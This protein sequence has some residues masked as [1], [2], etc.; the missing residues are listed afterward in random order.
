MGSFSV[1][2]DMLNLL[3]ILTTFGMFGMIAM[4]EDLVAFGMLDIFVVYM[5]CL[6]DDNCF[7]I[8]EIMLI[9]Q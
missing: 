8:M 1:S 5:V 7:V 2:W 6:I 3:S 4:Y 9:M